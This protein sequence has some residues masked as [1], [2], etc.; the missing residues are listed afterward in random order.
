MRN[1]GQSEPRAKRT[2]EVV[3]DVLGIL[4]KEYDTVFGTDA[5]RAESESEEECASP[6][7]PGEVW[8]MEQSERNR[9]DAARLDADRTRLVGLLRAEERRLEEARRDAQVAEERAAHL[10]RE[11]ASLR[12]ML[13][14]LVHGACAEL[15]AAVDP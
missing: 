7:M 10:A 8:C 4:R 12:E 6:R 14:E 5:C 15:R 2:A 3:A 11:R 1:S 13:A 9:A